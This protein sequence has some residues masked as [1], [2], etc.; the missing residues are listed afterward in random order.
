MSK[1]TCKAIGLVLLFAM[2]TCFC[3][4][5][6][7][8]GKKLDENGNPIFN[9]IFLK[10]TILGGHEV[11]IHYYT[12]SNNIEN[13]NS[14]VFVRKTP[15]IDDVWDFALKQPSYFFIIH[16]QNVISKMVIMAFDQSGDNRSW[17]YRIVDENGKEEIRKSNIKGTLTEL[18]YM[19]IG[20]KIPDS[21]YGYLSQN[22]GLGVPTNKKIF[23]KVIPF[24]RVIDDFGK[25]V[26]N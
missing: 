10:D 18:R 3:A 19:E 7:A 12:I 23:Y 26:L 16:K 20:G 1:K 14:S 13:R 21:S 4:A 9:S 15:S 17:T 11:A 8:S 6:C 5:G 25:T 2:A 22:E 24:L